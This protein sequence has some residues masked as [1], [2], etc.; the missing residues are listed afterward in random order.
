MWPFIQPGFA[1]AAVGLAAIP[2]AIHLL[3]RRRHRRE[4]WAAM[5][6]LERAQKRTR[7][8]TRLEQWL[9]LALR[10][11]VMALIALALARPVARSW[12]AV[13]PLR[14]QRVDRILI[15]DDSGS[16]QAHRADGTTEFQA[17]RDAALRL[18]PT[19]GPNDGVAV[20]TTGLAARI[21][22]ISVPQDEG[23]LRRVITG[24]SG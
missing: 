4:P 8:R 20:I 2:I 6:F 23:T 9:L 3:S 16:M 7:R 1:V 12:A 24:L 22:L 17:A 5:R 11:A 18:L 21:A 19:F 14:G 15:I 13:T 10:T